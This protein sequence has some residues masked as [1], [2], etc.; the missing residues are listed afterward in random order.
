MRKERRADGKRTPHAAGGDS[1]FD[2]WLQ[3]RRSGE[4]FLWFAAL[5]FFGGWVMGVESGHMSLAE[6]FAS[7]AW[8]VFLLGYLF[9]QIKYKGGDNSK[10]R[11][12]YLPPADRGEPTGDPASD[13]TNDRLPQSHISAEA[14]AGGRAA[15]GH[16]NDM[17]DKPD[18]RQPSE[19]YGGRRGR[20]PPGHKPNG[21]KGDG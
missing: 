18:T 11:Q 15:H 20:K 16:S 10:N 21:E 17:G 7:Q 6:S 5:Y 1:L 13:K 4:I 12:T 19:G 9:A 8:G 14:P 2:A 3:L